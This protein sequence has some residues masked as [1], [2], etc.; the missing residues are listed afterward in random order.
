MASI[1]SRTLF[2][3]T[4]IYLLH[5]QLASLYILPSLSSP[6]PSKFP[7]TQPINT[8]F[9]FLLP[10]HPSI[11]CSHYPTEVALKKATN[12]IHTATSRGHF[13]VP[14][15][16][17]LTTL[18]DT[19]GHSSVSHFIIC[20]FSASLNGFFSAHSLNSGFS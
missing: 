14:V 12:N 1:S 3:Q 6:F 19:A 17:S 11:F 5:I 7:K 20:F 13:S 8:V 4:P 10:S 16:F 15:S 9:G 18:L 2:H